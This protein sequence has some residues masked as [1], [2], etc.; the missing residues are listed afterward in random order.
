M[1]KQRA[2]AKA[3]RRAERAREQREYKKDLA[4]QFND[5]FKEQGLKHRFKSDEI[6]RAYGDLQREIAEE[7]VVTNSIIALYVMRRLHKF[8]A[9]RLHRLAG[10]IT[11]LVSGIGLNR[12]T[13]PQLEEALRND[14]H[15]DYCGYWNKA[16]IPDVHEEPFKH[17]RDQSQQR[18]NNR[19]FRR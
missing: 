11:V 16:S 17:R 14:A 1:D 19:D 2:K 3:R 12:R 18:T 8:G 9:L 5:K 4:R 7:A 13:L 6:A 10:E 15:I